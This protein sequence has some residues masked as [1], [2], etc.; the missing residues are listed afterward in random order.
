MNDWSTI[1]AIGANVA[2]ILGGV[3]A[4]ATWQRETRAR[5]DQRHEENRNMLMEIR[6]SVAELRPKV[7]AM[8]ARF[9]NE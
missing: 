4:F 7:E 9:L 2:A 6:D 8:W 3:V 1:I 5:V